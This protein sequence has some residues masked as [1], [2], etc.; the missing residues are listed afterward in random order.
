MGPSQNLIAEYNK[1]YPVWDEREKEMPGKAALL[2]VNTLLPTLSLDKLVLWT[3]TAS[4]WI[5]L[6]APRQRLWFCLVFNGNSFPPPFLGFLLGKNRLS[7][8][9]FG[10]GPQSCSLLITKYLWAGVN[11]KKQLAI[12]SQVLTGR[13]SLCYWAN[14]FWELNDSL[15]IT[16]R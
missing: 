15:V 13:I 5:S 6:S 7:R 1:I 2:L 4:A 9:N 11:L 3:L 16:I 8:D 14:A 12:M 10:S